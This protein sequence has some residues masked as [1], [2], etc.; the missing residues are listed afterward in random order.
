[1]LSK[2]IW[3]GVAAAACLTVRV[4][5]LYGDEFA[6]RHSVGDKFRIIS[7]VHEEYLQNGKLVNNS[8]IHNRISTEVL[9]INNDKALHKALFQVM[10][11]KKAVDGGQSLTVTN[12][13]PSLFERDAQGKMIVNKR[14]AFPS[15]RNV[16]AFPHRNLNVGES[17]IED[18]EEVHDLQNNFGLTDL[19]RIPV[20]AHYTYLGE[21][22][23]RGKKYPAFSVK[24]T[25]NQRLT[26]YF[27][28][29]PRTYLSRP[30]QPSQKKNDAQNTVPKEIVITQIL[31]ETNQTV[32]WD[33][34]LGQAAASGGVFTLRFNMSDGTVHEFRSKEEAEIIYAQDMDKD[35]VLNSI[36]KDLHDS[37]ID[38]TVKKVD[39]GISISMENIQFEGDSAVLRK[40]EK[41]KL[42]KITGI[43]AK[44]AER[45]IL[46]AGH[47]ADAGGSA[48][49][50]QKLSEDRALAVAGYLAA[51][52]VRPRERI[53]TKGYGA[54]QPVAENNTQEGRE[55]NRRVEII[56][57][58]N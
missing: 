14:Y 53:I 6:F 51:K 5:P 50:H 33:A 4:A 24:Y 17:W 25:I 31:G 57:L 11:N 48:E 28:K 27:E 23:W 37:G 26:D 15:V 36:E 45:D 34:G 56:I 18:G 2:K 30:N 40:S 13:Y 52:R 12:E 49:S 29:A 7:E 1:M 43:L 8:T 55:K 44:Y 41:A 16:P 35:E 47:T 22:V 9:N 42:D 32:Y 3:L 46:V 19:L 20:K 54:A 58:E 39:D 38:A 21:R 10:V